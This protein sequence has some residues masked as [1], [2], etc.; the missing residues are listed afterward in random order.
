MPVICLD[1]ERTLFEVFTINDLRS[2]WYDRY[3]RLYYLLWFYSLDF[4]YIL[5]LSNILSR[6]K[7]QEEWLYHLILS[8]SANS[9]DF[10][11]TLAFL[12]KVIDSL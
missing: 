10:Q 5:N 4:L 1:S 7:F 11:D 8:A 9:H 2:T 12:Q 3:R 6:C